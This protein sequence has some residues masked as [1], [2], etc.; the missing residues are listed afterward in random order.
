A[1]KVGLGS[2]AWLT[3][4]LAAALA[5]TVF[6]LDA[7]GLTL[8]VGKGAW[9][10]AWILMI[11]VPALLLFQIAESSGALAVLGDAL[12]TVAPTDGRLLLLLG[13]VFPSFLQG[14]AGF[15]TPVVV[16]APMLV[17]AGVPP[18]VAVA[19]CLVGYHWS[20]TFGSMGS[21]FFVASGVTQLDPEATAVFALRAASL[22]AVHVLAAAALLLAGA[23]AEMRDALPRALAI[24]LVMGAT[25]VLVVTVQP[26]L[27]S[28]AAGLAGLGAAAVVLP[29]RGQTPAWGRLVRAGAP[30]LLLTA[31]VVT[32]FGIPA[33]KEIAG[34]VPPLAPSFPATTAAFGPVNAA[35]DAHQP[36][37]PLLHPGLYVLIAAAFAAWRFWRIGGVGLTALAT[38]FRTVLHGWR[39]LS[40][41]TAG[42]LLGLTTL[43]AVMV[44]AGMIAAMA[45]ALTRALGPAYVAVAPAVG[46]VGTV[47]TG[48]TTAS[49]AL[50]SPLQASAAARL[51]LAE[52]A[53]LAGQT[54][55]GNVGNILAP[56]NVLIAAAAAGC[57]GEEAAILRQAAPPALALLALASLGTAL[58]AFGG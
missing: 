3:T 17:R 13:W 21:S 32:A 39:G 6:G 31:L 44:D 10:G 4:G 30:Y 54:V 37:R 26:A 15:G 33:V 48:S 24:G 55:G 12:S 29:A 28:T 36:L 56:I 45:E 38:P 23:R 42:S 34:R 16:A 7:V 18:A 1:F 53:L 58:F 35:I 49:N 20:V 19:T 25:L 51:H 57:R 2:A 14:T 22:L 8:A 40:A 46:A 27:G 52:S 11:V 9:T 47:L 41:K 50:L 43:A 5:G